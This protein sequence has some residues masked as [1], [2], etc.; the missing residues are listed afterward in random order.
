MEKRFGTPKSDAA[1]FVAACSSF[2]DV[3]V[4]TIY[5]EES[6]KENSVGTTK[7]EFLKFIDEISRSPRS[8]EPRYVEYSHMEYELQ[9]DLN[10][11]S[12]PYTAY[13]KSGFAY[14][15]YHEPTPIIAYC[16]EKWPY[17]DFG[18]FERKI[19]PSH[20]HAKV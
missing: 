8:V 7:T 1:K 2:P 18:S 10:R 20:S 4:G 3:R 14:K 6:C 16:T 13:D 15:A 19:L 12:F 17:P 11:Q 5:S 9:Q